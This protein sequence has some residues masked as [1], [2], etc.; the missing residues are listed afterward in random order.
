MIQRLKG[1][2][3]TIIKSIFPS[4]HEWLWDRYYLKRHRK[5]HDPFRWQMIQRCAEKKVEAGGAIVGDELFLFSGYIT[6]PLVSGLIEIYDFRNERWAPPV[7]FEKGLPN[8]HHGLASDGERYIYFAGGQMGPQAG[9]CTADASVFDVK[10]RSWKSFP[11]IPEGRYAPSVHIMEGRLHVIAGALPDRYGH[12]DDHWSIAIGDGIA[13]ESEWRSEPPIPHGGHHR[14]SVI[15]NGK[16]YVV[17]GQERDVRPIPNDP[18]YTCDW[19]TPFEIMYNDV[20]CY[21]PKSKR[22]DTLA[23]LPHATSHNEFST[24][25]HKQYVITAG[26]LAGRSEL[27]GD[28]QV[29]DTINDRWKNIGQLP[30]PMKGH[31]ALLHKETIYIFSGQRSISAISPKPGDVLDCGWKAALPDLDDLFAGADA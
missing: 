13:L 9:P 25:A 11:A 1:H 3:L 18:E 5:T 7:P 29:Y 24:F 8:S 2:I 12:A 14:G 20:Y 15:V 27:I 19:D 22:W 10:T 17:G 4:L 21:C 30:Y 16:L 28:I 31:V 23:P 26:G 6:L